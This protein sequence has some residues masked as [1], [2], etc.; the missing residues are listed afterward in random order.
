M[1]ILAGGRALHGSGKKFRHPVSGDSAPERARAGQGTGKPHRP[2]RKGRK[3]HIQHPGDRH[4]GEGRPPPS[5]GSSPP[6]PEDE[7]RVVVEPADG[8]GADTTATVL[9]DGREAGHTLREEVVTEPVEGLVRVGTGA[10]GDDAPPSGA[11]G[12]DWQA[13]ARCES[14]GDPGAGRRPEDRTDHRPEPPQT[15]RRAGAGKMWG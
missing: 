2:F 3:S 7:R 13:P 6:P 10:D 12:L 15:G 1:S 11:A 8:L 9:R 4:L 5:P 14:G